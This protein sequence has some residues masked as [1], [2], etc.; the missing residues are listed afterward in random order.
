M[1]RVLTGLLLLVL[2]GCGVTGE[3]AT[4]TTSASTVTK[5][6]GTT[7]AKGPLEENDPELEALLLGAAAFGA[8]HETPNTPDD[9]PED[10][11][12]KGHN[13]SVVPRRE[14]KVTYLTADEQDLFGEDLLDFDDDVAAR[15]F[16]S[17]LVSLNEVCRKI[18]PDLGIQLTFHPLTGFGDQALQGKP[19]PGADPFDFVLV[20]VDRRVI[21]VVAAGDRPHLPRSVI[22]AA[23]HRAAP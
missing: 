22:E 21:I 13:L 6:T 10:E 11:V 12:C 7:T 16:V 1:R 5:S 17:E 8:D 2:I 15:T 4:H 3:N 18:D 19:D 20:R 14:A 23:M 9:T